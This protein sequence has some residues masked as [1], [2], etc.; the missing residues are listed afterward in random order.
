MTR[1]ETLAGLKRGRPTTPSPDLLDQAIE[2]LL[3][4][5]RAYNPYMDEDRLRRACDLGRTA[6][7]GQQRASGQPYFT[8]PVAVARLLADMHMDLDTLSRPCCMIRLRIV[9][10][11]W[12]R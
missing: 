9:M 3:N 11:R 5:I 4:R 1:A 10:S 7:A 6:H 12:N 8:H 2:D